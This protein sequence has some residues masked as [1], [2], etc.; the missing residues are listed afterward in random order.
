M[1]HVPYLV[2]AQFCAY[3][4]KGPKEKDHQA[5]NFEVYKQK[6]VHTVIHNIKTTKVRER[7]TEDDLVE[8]FYICTG[9]GRSQNEK[10]YV[11]DETMKPT[12]GWNN[13][14]RQTRWSGS[15]S[16]LTKD[17]QKLIKHTESELEECHQKDG[18]Q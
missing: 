11:K 9:K 5:F 4:Q 8:I 17:I 7:F 14:M 10:H 3:F 6:K 1:L 18:C 12:S 16:Q 2:S 15:D 13:F